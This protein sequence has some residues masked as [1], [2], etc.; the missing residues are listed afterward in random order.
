[1]VLTRRHSLITILGVIVLA[2]GLLTI[3]SSTAADDS[4]QAAVDAQKQVL[5]GYAD[6][7]NQVADRDNTICNK[8][9]ANYIKNNNIQNNNISDQLKSASQNIQELNTRMADI[10]AAT[11]SFN[12]L[13]QTDAIMTGIKSAHNL[14][15]TINKQLGGIIDSLKKLN[16]AKDKKGISYGRQR[17]V[18]YA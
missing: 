17:D 1:M 13:S 12:D 5:V 9:F 15:E 2:L 18:S 10:N 8:F 11:Q 14:G 3:N 7:L 4:T 16:A 6:I